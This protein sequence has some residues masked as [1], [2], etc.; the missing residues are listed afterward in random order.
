MRQVSVSIEAL[1]TS[2]LGEEAG[3]QVWDS[4][5]TRRGF[6]GDQT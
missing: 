4:G 3:N 1:P 5:G 2:S 6:W